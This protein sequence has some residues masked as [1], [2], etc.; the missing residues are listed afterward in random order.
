VQSQIRHSSQSRIS[1][2]CFGL[3]CVTIFSFA[4]LVGRSTYATSLKSS[5][6]IE[7]S[8]T[9]V[10]SP[11][12]LTQPYSTRG[13]AFESVIS[14]TEPF[15]PTASIPFA[16]DN[17]TRIKLLA[18][19]L[20]LLP[21]D[22]FTSITAEAQDGSLRVY[23][24]R[25]EA[26]VMVPECDQVSYVVVRLDDSLGDVGDV[27]VRI[28]LH[29]LTSNRIRVGIG[30]IG[31]GP[32]DD[33][34][35][36]YAINGH[37]VDGSGNVLAGVLVNLTNAA[38]AIQSTTVTST[39]GD[40]SFIGLAPG[41]N[42]TVA[43]IQTSLFSFTPT[44]FTN[45]SANASPMF[46]GQARLYGISGRATVGSLGLSNVIITC[47]DGV[48]TTSALTDIT[49]NYSFPQMT[50]GRSI[51]VSA[52]IAGLSIANPAI[53]IPMLDG[54]RANIDF[55]ATAVPTPTPTPGPT[56]S[57]APYSNAVLADSPQ[58]YWPESETSGI[59]IGDSSGNSRT[60]TI[61][62]S[63]S[64]NASSLLFNN[65]ANPAIT[66]AGGSHIS[67]ASFWSV[68]TGAS[69]DF[70]VRFASV[71]GS[72][73][74]PT[75]VS[76]GL[77]G[78]TSD[79]A[80][81]VRYHGGDQALNYLFNYPGGT[82]SIEQQW[83]PV[84][85]RVYHVAVTHDYTNRTVAMY[86]DGA[87]V[88]NS[89]VSQT[90]LPFSGKRVQVA[91]PGFSGDLADVAI[92]SSALSA[93]RIRAH[94]AAA[95]GAD[96]TQTTWYA[97]PSGNIYARGTLDDPLDLHS[98][99]NFSLIQPGNTL[100]A[101]DGT[102][103]AASASSPSS[104]IWTLRL[105]GTPS[106][107]IVVKTASPFGAVLDGQDKR[108]HG[109]N[110]TG[111][112][113]D[114]SGF[115]IKKSFATRSTSQVN[116]T[117][118]P[119]TNGAGETV[120]GGG[121]NDAGMGNRVY[122]N[123]I[124]DFL[125]DGI[126]SFSSS[127]QGEYYGNIIAH[128]GWTAPRTIGGPIEG[129]GHGIYT[130]NLEANGQ[131][132]I[133]ENVFFDSYASPVAA[134]GSGASYV[135]NYLMRGN[136]CAYSGFVYDVGGGIGGINNITIDSE[137]LYSVGMAPGF[138]SSANRNAVVTNNYIWSSSTGAPA[139][140]LDFNSFT[141]T[142]NESGSL[143]N[144]SEGGLFYFRVRTG[145]FFS[146]STVDHNIYW[147][148]RTGTSN[149][150]FYAL[151][152]GTS[153]IQ[154]NFAAYKIATGWDHNS[155]WQNPSPS[156]FAQPTASKPF[157]RPI[158]RYGSGRLNYIV[159]NWSGAPTATLNLSSAGLVPGQTYKI[160]NAL[161]PRAGVVASGT[162]D[163]QSANVPLTLTTDVSQRYGDPAKSPGGTKQFNVF[164]VIPD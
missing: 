143:V 162:F 12:L 100:I 122:Y 30:H 20:Q 16:S 38:G 7:A 125:G 68:S 108:G 55:V 112:Y 98:A 9:T 54:N 65:P 129:N 73:S 105:S 85:G 70:L 103:T 147:Q 10:G 29:G 134:K 35:P 124:H 26:V 152:T 53:Q 2:I 79:G 69:M 39:S 4:T 11:V 36:G 94:F 82:V 106:N 60:A 137:M 128:N 161:N 1:P 78:S 138:N 62:G 40:F 88:A 13:L 22:D 23:P 136:V 102:Y 58:A 135:E 45:L 31:D 159:Y 77:Q 61:S 104:G 132:K 109:V 91:A 47:N 17:R 115:E 107:H 139:Q 71:P 133:E 144:A 154:T 43:P 93:S 89:I 37:V 44:S 123:Y 27:L 131:K 111:S 151:L 121:V 95:R 156:N 6:K 118:C 99:F 140:I 15:S 119:I 97:G 157:I 150:A 148:N 145:H 80:F 56:A 18:E 116:T 75:L 113:V 86:I 142:G 153:L 155:T 164:V 34:A 8:T 59:S 67:N 146:E 32:P 51:L 127:T 90:A 81:I 41:T 72:G 42:V 160:Y 101:K 33:P 117:T 130:Q 64:L 63:Y 28:S 14:T 24:L 96:P 114:L 50:S 76:A 149:V 84:V 110:I 21:G 25:V 66:F 57:P 5:A 120:G 52:A 48:A 92:Y 141:F 126:D 87:L 74:Y 49:G 19:S 46:F 163:P 158:T 3:L 83:V